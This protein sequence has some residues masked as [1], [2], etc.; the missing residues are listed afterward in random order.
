MSFKK[1]AGGKQKP[2]SKKRISI[3]KLVITL[4]IFSALFYLGYRLYSYVR[5]AYFYRSEHEEY[6]K[7]FKTNTNAIYSKAYFMKTLQ[8]YGVRDSREAQLVYEDSYIIPGL[9]STRTMIDSEHFAT[10]T[11]MTPQGVCVAGPYLLISAYCSTGKHNSVIY[12]INKSNHEFVKEIV[13]RGRPHVGGIA[14]DPIHKNVWFCDYSG[15]K[16]TAY[17]SAFSIADLRKYDIKKNKKP[18]HYKASIPIYSLQRTSFL[19]YSN[20]KLYVGHYENSL[21]SLTTIQSF[22]IDDL[23]GEIV[24]SDVYQWDTSEREDVILPSKVMTIK[25]RIQGFTINRYKS[26]LSTSYGILPSRV[27]IYD[28]NNEVKAASGTASS[29]SSEQVSSGASGNGVAGTGN[30]DAESVSGGASGSTSSDA[31]L[32]GE[33]DDSLRYLDDPNSTYNL[34]PMLEQISDYDGRLYLCFES[35]AYAYRAR[36]NRKMDRILVVDF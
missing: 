13:L 29:G 27:M 28:N 36:L 3:K 6:S 14:Y 20:K 7:E 25:S 35:A 2:A 30:S 34:P 32:D 17:V 22:T 31:E 15:K 21:S 18:I 11:S 12:V 19:D 1:K 33:P 26:A 5:Y 24:S 16:Q 23:T 4:I 8:K 9:M 10:C